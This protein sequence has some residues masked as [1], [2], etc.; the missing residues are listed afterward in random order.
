MAAS[1]TAAPPTPK[2]AYKCALDDGAGIRRHIDGQ[3][4]VM[5]EL[6]AEFRKDDAVVKRTINMLVSATPDGAKKLAEQGNLKAPMRSEF[7][8]P[9]F[10]KACKAKNG[11]PDHGDAKRLMCVRT[12]EYREYALADH[13]RT[14]QDNF[15]QAIVNWTNA[16]LLGWFG[17][18]LTV[19]LSSLI[20]VSP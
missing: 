18:F 5:V 11:T 2:Y 8:E 17:S 3:G 12:D 9:I 19:T 16:R 10:S 4:Y 1:K 13:E 20:F 14:L 6:P 7:L 15:Y